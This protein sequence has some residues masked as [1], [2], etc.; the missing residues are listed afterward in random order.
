MIKDINYFLTRDISCN[1]ILLTFDNI[2]D[3]YIYL[4][5]LHENLLPSIPHIQ[6]MVKASLYYFW[7]EGNKG[8]IIISSDEKG[9][10]CRL[11]EILEEE[12]NEK[13]RFDKVRNERKESCNK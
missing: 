5:Y 8:Q 9:L 13:S 2:D 3:A 11:L 4:K 10:I 1:Y 12:N 6:H 7:Y